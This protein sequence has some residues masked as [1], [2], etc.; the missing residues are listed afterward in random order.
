MDQL[1]QLGYIGIHFEKYTTNNSK[2]FNS[3]GELV[4]LKPMLAIS[5]SVE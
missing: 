2:P 4:S 1:D 3:S 5:L